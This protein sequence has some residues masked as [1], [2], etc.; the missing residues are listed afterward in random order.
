M[1]LRQ[2]LF[3][4]SKIGVE[5]VI[6]P[7]CTPYLYVRGRVFP[8]VLFDTILKRLENVLDTKK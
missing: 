1:A 6:K 7:K 4:V 3:L 5:H 8:N 2:V